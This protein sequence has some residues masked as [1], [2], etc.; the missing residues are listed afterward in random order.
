M[1]FVFESWG[2]WLD[3]HQ[4]YGIAQGID[5]N[6]YEVGEWHGNEWTPGCICG[7]GNGT[8]V[9]VGRAKSGRMLDGREWNPVVTPVP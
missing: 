7:I 8:V 6:E 2:Y 9:K 1:E 5:R 4:C 3:I